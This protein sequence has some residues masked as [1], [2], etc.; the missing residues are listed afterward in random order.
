M[1][2][3]GGKL[4]AAAMRYSIAHEEWVDLSTGI[5]P[6]GW[7]VPAVPPEVWR[8][9]PEA[10]DGLTDAAINYYGSPMIL[11]TAG[12]QPVIQLL[13]HLRP[14]CRVG[15]LSPS[16]A[17]H[18]YAWRGHQLVDLEFDTIDMQLDDLDVLVLCNP[19]NP[20]GHRFAPSTLLGWRERLS[21][22]GGWLVVDEAFIDSSP[23]ISIAS[24]AGLPGLVVL[25]SMGKFF[26]IAGARVGFVLA[27]QALLSRIAEELGPWSVS[28]LARWVATRALQDTSWQQATRQN[29][30]IDSTRLADMLK[31][32]KLA[33]SGATALFQWVISPHAQQLHESL[34]KQ[35]I[36]TRYFDSPKSVRFGMPC[37]EKE[38]LRLETALQ[39]FRDIA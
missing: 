31:K 16:Y 12:S 3:H 1:L 23:E 20:T 25:R 39:K 22:R 24:H 35:G 37:P 9:L 5:N 11:P 27:W 13:P 28:G 33:P 10:E 38:W 21:R 30:V 34:A 32:Y 17:E 29:L 14:A 6:R 18:S 19:N 26:G 7:P 15:L 2:E 36:L 4:R 8:R